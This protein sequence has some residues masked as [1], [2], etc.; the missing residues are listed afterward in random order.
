MNSNKK[1]KKHEKKWKNLTSQGLSK[2]QCSKF[3]DLTYTCQEG[4]KYQ[5]NQG[6]MNN[7]NMRKIVAPTQEEQQQGMD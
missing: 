1:M 4:G 3:R 5:T 2:V 7:T 6:N